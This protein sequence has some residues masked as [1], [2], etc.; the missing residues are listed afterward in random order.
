MSPETVSDESRPS[1]IP[2]GPSYTVQ[3]S[4]DRRGNGC[5]DDIDI[6]FRQY[7]DSGHGRKNSA[8]KSQSMFANESSSFNPF[9][10]FNSSSDILEQTSRAHHPDLVGLDFSGVPTEQTEEPRPRSISL[11]DLK[12]SQRAIY[13]DIRHAFRDLAGSQSPSPTQ[14]V[15]N[16]PAGQKP[17]LPTYLGLRGCP[18][19]PPAATQPPVGHVRC[20]S[21]SPTQFV[22]NQAVA[23][24]QLLPNYLG[25]SVQACSTPPP[26]PT[27]PPGG[28]GWNPFL[29]NYSAFPPQQ[30]RPS[31]GFTSVPFTSTEQMF[32]PRADHPSSSYPM[33]P[34][35]ILFQ[36]NRV[37]AFGNRPSHSELEH[38]AASAA[39]DVNPLNSG[40]SSSINYVPNI[41]FLHTNSVDVPDPFR[42]FSQSPT[43]NQMHPIIIAGFDESFSPSSTSPGQVADGDLIK[44]GHNLPEHEYLSLDCFDPLYSR[45][46]RESVCLGNSSSAD[47]NFSFGEAFPNVYDDHV[48]SSA[49]DDQ[50]DDVWSPKS[51]M[52]PSQQNRKQ[53][54]G[55]E[56]F[57]FE[58]FGDVKFGKSEE[59]FMK[60]ALPPTSVSAAYDAPARQKFDDAPRKAVSW[61]APQVVVCY[62]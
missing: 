55:F 53:N 35:S 33:R 8:G 7:M 6:N 11:E 16:Q 39:Y 18:T 43:D 47:L 5:F 1:Q 28:Y 51:S 24:K 52:E 12:E 3:Q 31:S 46:R 50:D 40:A 44:L 20:Q 19:P 42:E 32:P 49:N 34:D 54:I 38:Q 14:F 29:L 45:A 60:E 4:S 15:V 57:D 58:S 36:N 59:E 30:S 26:V 9:N 25:V 10:P 17:L 48:L 21:P 27:Q 13:P 56:A 41:T 61:A 2:C 22:A 37:S 62:L 23:Q